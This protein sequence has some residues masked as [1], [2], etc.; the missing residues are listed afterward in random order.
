MGPKD[1]CVKVEN[2]HDHIY[3]GEI[4]RDLPHRLIMGRFYV[5][6]TMI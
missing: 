6:S 4:L 3:H 5:T 2:C 1:V